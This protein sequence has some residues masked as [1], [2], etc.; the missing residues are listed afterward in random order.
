MAR[1]KKIIVGDGRPI[2]PPEIKDPHVLIFFRG[3]VDTAHGVYP[4]KK[5]AEKALKE[6]NGKIYNKKLCKIYPQ[7]EY[8]KRYNKGEFELGKPSIKSRKKK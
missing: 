7:E 3:K 5:K 2:P 1:R 6:L 8:F 4:T